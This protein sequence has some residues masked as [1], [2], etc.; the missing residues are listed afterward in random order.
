VLI[1]RLK[2]LKRIY[3]EIKDLLANLFKNLNN[4]SIQVKLNNKNK[5]IATKNKIDNIKTSK[6]NNILIDIKTISKFF[7][8][9]NVLHKELTQSFKNYIIYENFLKK[10]AKEF[11]LFIDKNDYLVK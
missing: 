2:L 7:V 4:T 1:D 6:R 10:L 8:K 3:R 11:A 5:K 9:R